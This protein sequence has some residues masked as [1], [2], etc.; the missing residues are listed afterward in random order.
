MLYGSGS[1]CICVCVFAR[2]CLSITSLCSTKTAEHKITQT[3]PHDSPGTLFFLCQRSPR[4]STRGTQM[5]W[6]KSATFD[7]QAGYI[8]KTVQDRRRD[9]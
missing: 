6:V 4:N 5:G 3:K 8:S 9:A 7:E 2:L 1:V